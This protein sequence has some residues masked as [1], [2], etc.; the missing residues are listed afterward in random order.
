M[1]DGYI[2]IKLCFQTSSNLGKKYF[3]MVFIRMF[4]FWNKK[5]KDLD[6]LFL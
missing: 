6:V 2:I 5:R 3:R 1:N 4:V